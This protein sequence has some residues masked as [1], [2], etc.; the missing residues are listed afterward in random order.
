LALIACVPIRRCASRRARLHCPGAIVGL[1]SAG[2]SRSTERDHAASATATIP[3]LLAPTGSALSQWRQRSTPLSPAPGS[4]C[5]AS[6]YSE[7]VDGSH[8][9]FAASTPRAGGE[10]CH[11]RRDPHPAGTIPSVAAPPACAAGVDHRSAGIRL[12]GIRSYFERANLERLGFKGNAD[13]DRTL[14][15]GGRVR[16]SLPTP[17]CGVE[18]SQ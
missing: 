17:A 14:V 2:R 8:S 18:G 9:R 10:E 6:D 3:F 1:G 7:G 12:C 16:H 15:I 11:H 5:H 4:Q 13:A